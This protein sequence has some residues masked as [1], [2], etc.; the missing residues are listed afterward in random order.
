MNDAQLMTYAE[1][2]EL[3]KIKI[4]SVKRRARN[5]RWHREIGND[6]L[7]R[8]AVPLT[9]LPDPSI[10]VQLDNLPDRPGGQI[11]ADKR[12]VALEV[13]VK[14]LRETLQDLRRDRDAWRTSATHRWWH[15]FMPPSHRHR[16]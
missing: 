3:M 10:T 7:V 1:A 11:E 15:N 14:M 5:R 16:D 13:E 6:G 4:D 8:I 12:I 9:A 2:A